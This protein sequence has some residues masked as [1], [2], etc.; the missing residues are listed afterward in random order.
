MDTSLHAVNTGSLNRNFLEFQEINR[1]TMINRATL[2]QV[3]TFKILGAM[4]GV[5]KR[6]VFTGRMS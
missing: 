4:V 6:G 3:Q 2:L 1:A 5:Q